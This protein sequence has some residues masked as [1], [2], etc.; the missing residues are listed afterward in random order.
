MSGEGKFD[1]EV[2]FFVYPPRLVDVIGPLYRVDDGSKERHILDSCR[3][4]WQDSK[5]PFIFGRQGMGKSYLLQPYLEKTLKALVLEPK[6][7]GLFGL[8][9][10]P[11]RVIFLARVHGRDERHQETECTN[12]ISS[13]CEES[14]RLFN[15]D[16]FRRGRLG[17]VVNEQDVDRMAL[18][19]VGG[20]ESKLGIRYKLGR[21]KVVE[22]FHQFDVPTIYGVAC[23]KNLLGL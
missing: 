23:L 5:I 1:R 22:A 20:D 8:R 15:P 2:K 12:L 19:L 16:Q 11:E 10:M 9:T 21:K 3:L 4:D 18:A 7:P 13:V 14:H 17:L 6:I